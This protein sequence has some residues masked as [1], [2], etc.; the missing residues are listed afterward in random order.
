VFGGVGLLA[1]PC[2]FN[3]ILFFFFFF[4]FLKKEEEE[5]THFVCL[6]LFSLDWQLNRPISGLLYPTANGRKG[7]VC[8][9]LSW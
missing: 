3:D 7:F 6:F 4:I 8:V 2:L 5:K 9:S 1:S